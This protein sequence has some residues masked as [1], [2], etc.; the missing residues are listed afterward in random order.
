MNEEGMKGEFNNRIEIEGE[1]E[2]ERDRKRERERENEE[3]R[4]EEN[5]IVQQYPA[6][7]E[8]LCLPLGCQ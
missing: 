2:Q 5:P 1:R 3:A 7:S 6:R 4:G 8:A